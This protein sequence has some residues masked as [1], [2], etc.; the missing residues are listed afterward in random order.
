MQYQSKHD[1][2]SLNEHRKFDFH[3]ER[4]TIFWNL[5]KVRKICES[6]LKCLLSDPFDVVN[7]LWKKNFWCE[8]EDW[9]PWNFIKLLGRFFEA[10]VWIDWRDC[11][12]ETRFETFLLFA[13]AKVEFTDL[14]K[15]KSF[16]RNI[17]CQSL[18]V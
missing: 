12:E 17:F 1:K 8:C 2:S 10:F 9:K 7:V 3:R 4:K 18:T 5:I 13:S 6:E 11:F 15:P 16:Q 14:S